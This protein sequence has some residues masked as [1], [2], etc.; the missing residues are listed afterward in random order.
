M[1]KLCQIIAVT[2]G[3]KTSVQKDIT[4]IHHKVTKEALLQGIARTYTPKDD[5]GEKKPALRFRYVEVINWLKS[6]ER[7]S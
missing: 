2:N 5:S 1:A 7:I 6:R 3:R 4:E